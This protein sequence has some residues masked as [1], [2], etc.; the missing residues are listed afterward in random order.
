MA[1]CVAPGDHHSTDIVSVYHGHA[2]PTIL[3]GYHA[4]RGHFEQYN[5][6]DKQGS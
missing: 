5:D 6:V 3:C 4:S 1:K 2:T